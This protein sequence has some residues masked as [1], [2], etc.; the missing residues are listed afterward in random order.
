M[1]LGFGSLLA[2]LIFPFFLTISDVHAQGP[3]MRL[4][5]GLSSV[6]GTGD[7]FVGVG[8]DSRLTWILNQDLSIGANAN[9]INYILK[10]RDDAAYFFHPS[11]STIVTLNSTST[12]SPYVIVGLGMNIPLAGD[13]DSF[14]SGP[15]L[16]AGLGWVFS[17]QASSLYLELNPSLIVARSAVGLQIPARVGI[18]L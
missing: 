12:T 5:F 1:R 18:I 6:A 13:A 9:F 11:V 7:Q 8:V 16:H 4:G 10:G 17:L 2:T 14:E 3:Q 15:S